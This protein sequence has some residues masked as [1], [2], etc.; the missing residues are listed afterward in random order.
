MKTLY[1]DCKMGAAGDM[2]T[3]V[4]LGL[5]QDPC[6]EVSELNSVGI[7]DVEFNYELVENNGILGGHVSVKVNGREEEVDGVE[8]KHGD[9]TAHGTEAHDHHHQH[10][11]HSHSHTMYDIEEIIE[12]LQLA[13]EIKSDIREVYALIADAESKVHGKPVSQ[14]HFH[15][16]GNMD[17]IAD[18]TAVCYLMHKIDP[19]KVIVSPINVGGGTVKAS[20]GIM[21][22]PAP[23]TA[24]LLSGIPTY[25]SH[26][27]KSELCTPTG[28]A[29]LKYFADEFSVQPI[30]AVDKISYGMGNKKFDQVNAIRVMLGETG[31]DSEQVVELS[32]NIDDMT[33]EEVGFATEALFEAGALEVYTIATDMKKN[34][35]GIELRCICKMDKR[36]II[37]KHIFKHTTTL[38]VRENICNRY[39]LTREINKIETPYGEVR[40]KKAYGYDV[41]RSKLEYDDIA[42]IARRTGKS[43]YELRKELEEN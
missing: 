6:K 11:H 34:R 40:V 42:G 25:E 19:D 23:A 20:H 39:V 15:E 9:E 37:L 1:F 7:P 29:L 5:F 36:D 30:M 2:I 18:V 17:A 28:A 27:I 3:A 31:D 43:L 26:S 38:G 10:D 4:L 16:V 12:N 14:I 35:P 21:P 33:A 13:K 32:C 41:S 22:V 8:H 24:L